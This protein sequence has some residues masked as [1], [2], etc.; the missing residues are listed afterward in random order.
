MSKWRYQT[1]AITL[2]ALWLL[3]TTVA[4]AQQPASPATAGD[5]SHIML[6]PEEIKWGE[7]P[8]DIPPGAKC[9]VIEGDPNVA[10]ALFTIRAKMPDNYRIP[11]HFHPTDEHVV[12]L[13]GV[14]N[15]GLGDKLDVE[16]G[17][18]MTTGSF[19]V[20]PK[21]MHHFAWT[22]GETVV[23]VYAVGPMRFTYVNPNDDPRKR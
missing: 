10:G 2:L 11:A 3:S 23:Q 1:R 20:M 9:A 21:G 14:F 6:T 18:A 13:S 5:K 17:R 15:M 8:P 7:C 16:A 19:M 12:V 22:S 4:R